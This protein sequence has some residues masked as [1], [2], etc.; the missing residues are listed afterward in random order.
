MKFPKEKILKHRWNIAYYTVAFVLFCCSY[1]FVSENWKD[2]FSGRSNF[3]NEEVPIQGE[4]TIG[5]CFDEPTKGRSFFDI[6]QS[7]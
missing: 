7:N 6:N 5:I 4:P 3:S 2:Y 1:F